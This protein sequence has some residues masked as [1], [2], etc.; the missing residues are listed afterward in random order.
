[1]GKAERVKGHRYEQ[2]IAKEMRE[3]GYKDCETSRY[4]S[5]KL[6]DAKVDLAGLPFNVQCK[7]YKKQ[8]SFRPIL[9]EMPNEERINTIFHKMPYKEDIVVMTKKDFYKLLQAS[10][11]KALK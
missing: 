1:M 7:A 9:N 8:P 10:K 5:K 3:L 2:Q 4:V 6:D 11:I